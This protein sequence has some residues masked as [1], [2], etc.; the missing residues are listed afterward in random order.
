MSQSNGVGHPLNGRA[1]DV[2]GQHMW[3]ME[4]GGSM[5]EVVFEPYHKIQDLN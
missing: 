4:G 1:A 2:S 5:H 3:S